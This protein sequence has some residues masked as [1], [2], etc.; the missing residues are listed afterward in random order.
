MEGSDQEVNEWLKMQ[1]I[2]V[3]F[4][5]LPNTQFNVFPFVEDEFLVLLPQNHA[6]AA[7]DHIALVQIAAEPFIM[8]SGGC[9]PLINAIFTTAGYTPQTR[10]VLRDMN[11]IVSFV[12]VGLG[13]SIVPAL[14]LANHP[15]KIATVP[16]SPSVTRRIGIAVR[17]LESATPLT[18]QFIDFITQPTRV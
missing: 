5:A 13:I 8:S 14:A 4:V 16:L 12:E 2:D 11:S 17:S 6:Y 18:R 9:E 10:F 1:Q 3:G 15:R 7:E